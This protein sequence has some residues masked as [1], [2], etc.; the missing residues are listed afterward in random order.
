MTWELLLP[1]GWARPGSH[2]CSWSLGLCVESLLVCY[3]QSTSIECVM[4]RE[5]TGQFLCFLISSQ[6]S[7]PHLPLSPWL[8]PRSVFVT[9]SPRLSR[10]DSEQLGQLCKRSKQAWDRRPAALPARSHICWLHS[11]SDLSLWWT[12]G[13]GQRLRLRWMER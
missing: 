2:L 9:L 8:L 13:R 1:P 4:R 7:F 6:P 12:V 11:Q 3:K 10:A 5:K